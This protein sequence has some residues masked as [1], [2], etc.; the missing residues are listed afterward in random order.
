MAPSHLCRFWYGRPLDLRGFSRR[1]GAA[2]LDGS[3]RP[4]LRLGLMPGGFACPAPCSF[5]RGYPS[6]LRACLA[7]SPSDNSRG[8]PRNVDRVSIAYA[9]RPRLRSRLTPGGRTCPGKPW[10]SGG[11]DFHPSFRYSCPHHHCRAVHGG[12]RP[13]FDPSRHAP[14]PTPCGVPRLR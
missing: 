12:F 3:P 4:C 8:R 6:P 5:R 10:D 1:I 9:L 11:R 14:L 7:P 13:R 2:R